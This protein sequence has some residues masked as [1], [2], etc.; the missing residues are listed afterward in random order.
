MKKR[1]RQRAPISCIEWRETVVNNEGM[2]W[3][4]RNVLAMAIAIF[5]LLTCGERGEKYSAACGLAST[6]AARGADSSI[7]DGERTVAACDVA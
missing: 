2:W 4:R 1:R 3:Y 7:V 6:A 5:H